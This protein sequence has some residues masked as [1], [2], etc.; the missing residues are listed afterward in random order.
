MTYQIRLSRYLLHDVM[1]V[2]KPNRVC[3]YTHATAVSSPS[4]NIQH[5][6]MYIIGV[7]AHK[8]GITGTRVRRN[9]LYKN[10]LAPF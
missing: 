9:G 5:T 8:R 10:R 6:Y 2:W 4:Y 3:A 7:R 1:C